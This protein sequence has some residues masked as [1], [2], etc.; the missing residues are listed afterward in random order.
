EPDFGTREEDWPDP[1]VDLDTEEGREANERLDDL[2]EDSMERRLQWRRLEAA[3]ARQE[4]YRLE[5]EQIARALAQPDTLTQEEM[6]EILVWP[7]PDITHAN[8]MAARD[9]FPGTPFEIWARGNDALAQGQPLTYLLNNEE[10]MLLA[11]S[12]YTKE[13]YDVVS[14]TSALMVPGAAEAS[15]LLRVRLGLDF[16]V[17]LAAMN[18]WCE[19]ADNMPKQ[20]HWPQLPGEPTR[21][22]RFGTDNWPHVPYRRS[23]LNLFTEEMGLSGWWVYPGW[24]ALNEKQ[25]QTYRDRSEALR[26]EASAKYEKIKAVVAK[27]NIE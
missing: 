8:I 13:T 23:A 20:P 2:M 14:W 11:R 1:D 18:H 26:L 25:R 12:F 19:P 22:D 3:L 10:I 21:E 7:S 9:G 16:D 24:L 27:K 6:Y 5:D 15:K 17:M 4:A